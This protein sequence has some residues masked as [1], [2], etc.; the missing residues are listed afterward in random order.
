M[1]IGTVK[2][3]TCNFRI[4]V[5]N[6]IDCRLTTTITASIYYVYSLEPIVYFTSNVSVNKLPLPQE[7]VLNH[8]V[9]S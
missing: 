4:I 3:T 6:L 1:D 8:L 7:L 9:L 2:T 5:Y